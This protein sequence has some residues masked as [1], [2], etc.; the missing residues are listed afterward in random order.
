MKEIKYH[1]Y[2]SAD[3]QAAIIKA[4]VEL[5]NHL[6]SMGKYTDGVDDVIIKMTA[7]KRKKL[8]VQYI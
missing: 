7:A 2:L 8:N 5:K 1:L 3:E 4:L 6:A